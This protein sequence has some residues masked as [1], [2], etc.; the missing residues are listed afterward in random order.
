MCSSCLLL[1]SP[2]GHQYFR[3]AQQMLCRHPHLLRW[4]AGAS[5]RAPGPRGAMGMLLGSS[6]GRC[7]GFL[8]VT[9]TEGTTSLQNEQTVQCTGTVGTACQRTKGSRLLACQAVN[10]KPAAPTQAIRPAG[11]SKRKS[12]A[13]RHPP[14]RRRHHGRGRPSTP[15]WWRA[16]Q[17]R[18]RSPPVKHGRRRAAQVTCR[19]RHR[20][21]GWSAD[22]CSWQAGERGQLGW[23]KGGGCCCWLPSSKERVGLAPNRGHVA[24]QTGQRLPCSRCCRSLERGPPPR[25]QPA[26]LDPRR[27]ARGAPRLSHTEAQWALWLATWLR[28]RWFRAHPP[29]AGWHAAGASSGPPPSPR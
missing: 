7:S 2:A 8:N 21:R 18:R 15:A 4:R 23:Q 28:L 26:P 5:A 20:C 14:G 22:C 11:M 16:A 29:A 9:R 17:L 10:P 13:A 19:N 12:A 25:L 27:A 1:P 3:L 24:F 6:S